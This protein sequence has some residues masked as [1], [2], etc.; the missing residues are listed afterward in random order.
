MRFN[1]KRVYFVKVYFYFNTF[2]V[3]S[4][5]NGFP[6]NS[7]IFYPK[8]IYVF[9]ILYSEKSKKLKII[10]LKTFNEVKRIVYIY[11]EKVP[12]SDWVLL[13][14][15][16]RESTDI[17][18]LD[19]YYRKWKWEWKWEKIER[20]FRRDRKSSAKGKVWVWWS[21]KSPI[22]CTSFHTRGISPYKNSLVVY[23]KKGNPEK[24]KR[25]ESEGKKYPLDSKRGH[26]AVS[27]RS[28]RTLPLLIYS[29]FASKCVIMIVTLTSA[30][31]QRA[32]KTSRIAKPIHSFSLYYLH[33]ALYSLFLPFHFIWNFFPFSVPDI[34]KK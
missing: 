21:S 6:V 31:L 7:S 3:M 24:L 1:S 25:S 30:V 32:L 34:W 23:E 20:I 22:D 15:Q 5:I 16:P 26:V 17:K 12:S 8:L 19:Q 13:F 27:S 4:S 33:Y 2:V 28:N 10:G 29:L 18:V 11:A 14:Q 9:G